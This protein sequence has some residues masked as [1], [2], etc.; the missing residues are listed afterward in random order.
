MI[1]KR[2]YTGDG[3]RSLGHFLGRAPFAVPETV[4]IYAIRQRAPTP[5]GDFLGSTGNGEIL[6]FS[7]GAYGWAPEGLQKLAD[8]SGAYLG[9]GINWALLEDALFCGDQRIDTGILPLPDVL[10]L[11]EGGDDSWILRCDMTRAPLFLREVEALTTV[12]LGTTCYFPGSL[13]YTEKPEAID[14]LRWLLER[15]PPKERPR[16]EERIRELEE[17]I[18]QLEMANESGLYGVVYYDCSPGIEDGEIAEPAEGGLWREGFLYACGSRS[19]GRGMVIPTAFTSEGICLGLSVIHSGEIQ[20]QGDSWISPSPGGGVAMAKREGEPLGNL[21][22]CQSP[23]AIWKW[24]EDPLLCPF[25]GAG[26]FTGSGAVFFHEV[27]EGRHRVALMIPTRGENGIH[28][29]WYGGAGT[30][31]R[32]WFLPGNGLPETVWGPF[33]V[34]PTPGKGF[35]ADFRSL[36]RH[37]VPGKFCGI[38]SR[39]DRE[40]LVSVHAT[41]S[42]V[43]LTESPVRARENGGS[44][45]QEVLPGEIVAP[46]TASLGKPLEIGWWNFPGLGIEGGEPLPEN[47]G[48][49]NA[50]NDFVK[51][52]LLTPRR[53]MSVSSD[54]YVYL[55]GDSGSLELMAFHYDGEEWEENRLT[56]PTNETRVA[57]YGQGNYKVLHFPGEDWSIFH[58]PT[59]TIK[60]Q[61]LLGEVDWSWMLPLCGLGGGF[62][63]HG[64]Y[65]LQQSM[66]Q[67]MKDSFGGLQL[68][69]SQP[70]NV[71]TLGDPMFRHS[72]ILSQ[73]DGHFWTFVG[74]ETVRG[75]IMAIFSRVKNATGWTPHVEVWGIDGS[76]AR[77][78]GP[79]E[80]GISGQKALVTIPSHYFPRWGVAPGQDGGFGDLLFDGTEVQ[81]EMPE[82]TGDSGAALAETVLERFRA[83]QEK[84]QDVNKAAVVAGQT[85]DHQ[86]ITSATV[87]P[88]C[89]IVEAR[90]K[91]LDGAIW[92]ILRH[93]T[94]I[95]LS[96][97]C[98]SELEK[99]LMETDRPWE[100]VSLGVTKEGAVIALFGAGECNLSIGDIDAV[101]EQYF[102]LGHW[103]LRYALWRWYAR[104]IPVVIQTDFEALQKTYALWGHD[105]EQEE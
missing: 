43:L 95:W 52:S 32:N 10:N 76:G 84:A 25:E 58:A 12:F 46:W 47:L 81:Y 59:C 41:E 89:P 45:S 105:I 72:R 49:G 93:E 91:E 80:A 61:K 30:T 26:H 60:Y 86:V 29:Q 40:Y 22:A 90:V 44:Y 35:V 103:W 53:G 73:G 42:E 71:I 7:S 17:E 20:L 62:A 14:K 2:I 51:G 94:G 87:D 77:Q 50:A 11:D 79:E 74:W 5:P 23:G 101:L 78:L 66:E 27:E 96:V 37:V 97:R 92:I 34:A 65:M 63:L 99:V 55:T 1:K 102:G 19:A 56:I 33:F 38:A 21:P 31:I 70:R 18:K 24:G 104:L 69:Y 75:R 16:I 68:T 57:P 6:F 39:A 36:R 9:G 100:I 85:Y 82:P 98:E 67:Y 28:P 64:A 48:D 8:S 3:G 13:S 54:G 88:M 15:V 83:W 4:N